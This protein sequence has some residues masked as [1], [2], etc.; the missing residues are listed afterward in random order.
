M[1]RNADRSK[2]SHLESLQCFLP[3]SRASTPQTQNVHNH[4]PLHLGQYCRHPT[5]GQLFRE[6]LPFYSRSREDDR[7][8]CCRAD[9]R[10][11]RG[12]MWDLQCD[13]TQVFASHSFPILQLEDSLSTVCTVHGSLPTRK[14]SIWCDAKQRGFRWRRTRQI[15]HC[16]CLC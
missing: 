13:C 10:R 4:P 6:V 5:I 3:P 1:M 12:A 7:S 11:C 8:P 14:F 2:C 16:H 15:Q 9:E